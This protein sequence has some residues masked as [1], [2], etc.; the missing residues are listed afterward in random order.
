MKCE[1]M[2]QT[3]ELGLIL[4]H[5]EYLAYDLEDFQG[6][7]T[8]YRDD[9]SPCSLCSFMFHYV[10]RLVS[11]DSWKLSALSRTWALTCPTR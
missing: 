7:E 2:I 9:V 10:S 3:D 11:I 1:D 6:H 5:S 8:I 4:K